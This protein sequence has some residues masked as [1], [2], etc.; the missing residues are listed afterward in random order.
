MLGR[1]SAGGRVKRVGHYGR[2]RGTERRHDAEGRS[3]ACCGSTAACCGKLRNGETSRQQ[4]TA[5]RGGVHGQSEV[6]SDSGQA[7]RSKT[8]CS[9]K[10]W[11][12]MTNTSDHE[13]IP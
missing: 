7:L 5:R 6:L 10:L 1:F 2:R 13:R 12:T 8:T 9:Q 4:I 11:G 3:A